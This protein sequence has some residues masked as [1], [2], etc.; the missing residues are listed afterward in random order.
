M[1]EFDAATLQIVGISA[2]LSSLLRLIRGKGILTENE[3]DSALE[4]AED[5]TGVGAKAD[6]H[7]LSQEQKNLVLL[8]IRLLRAMN[9]RG[10]ET[11]D[12]PDVLDYVAGKKKES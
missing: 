7:N 4:A 11:Q 5:A 1:A 9:R 2:A 3:I 12:G 6:T 10:P 8:P